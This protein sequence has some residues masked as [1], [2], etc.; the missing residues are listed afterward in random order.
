MFVCLNDATF[1]LNAESV[2]FVK[3][4]KKC[5]GDN[6]PLLDYFFILDKISENGCL[7]E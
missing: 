2:C 1:L 3:D 7:I 6:N 4:H 5:V